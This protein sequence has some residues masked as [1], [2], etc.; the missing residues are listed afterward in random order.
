MTRPVLALALIVTGLAGCASDPKNEPDRIRS[1]DT[2]NTRVQTSRAEPIDESEAL[3]NYRRYLELAEDT[4]ERQEALRRVADLQV[5]V[6]ESG[7]ATGVQVDSIAYYEELLQRYPDAAANDRVLYQLARAHELEGNDAAA[8]ATFERLLTHYP[9][10]S[11]AE[12]VRFRRAELLFRERRYRDAEQAYSQLVA[13]GPGRFYEKALYKQGWARYKQSRYVAALGPFDSLLREHAAAYDDTGVRE[14]AG[15]RATTI[16]LDDSLRTMALSLSLMG[17]AG[18]ALAQLD[19]LGGPPYDRALRHRLASIYEQKQRYTDAA[20]VFANQAERAGSQQDALR[21][22]AALESGGFADR[23]MAAKAGYLRS[24]D[25]AEP[26][27]SANW[28]RELAKHHHALAQKRKDARHY[29]EAEHWY[30][31]YLDKH[32]GFP[33]V[34]EQRFLLA[35]L[36]FEQ[37]RYEQAA[38]EYAAA[39]AA[40]G[41]RAGDAAYAAVLARRGALERLSDNERS[42]RRAQ[43]VEQDLA[44]ATE[45]PGHPQAAAVRLRA[46]EDL[47]ELGRQD[48]AAAAAQPLANAADSGIRLGAL[49]IIAAQAAT[50]GE[51]AAAATAYA[52]AIPLMEIGPRRNE[53]EQAW[54]TALYR[55]GEQA[56]EAG[57]SAT[58][59][60]R[61]REVGRRTPQAAIR[62][63]ADYDAASLL[64]AEQRWDE[65]SGLLE[66]LLARE[67]GHELAP[68]AR[69]KLALAY[70]N[71]G[72]KLDAARTLRSVAQSSGAGEIASAADWQAAELLREACATAEAATAYEQY[73]Q[74]YPD[75]FARGMEARRHLADF[76]ARSG[77]G[78]NYREHLQEIIRADARGGGQRS[79]RSRTLAAEASMELALHA[80]EVFKAARL[81][82]P[83]DRSLKDKTARMDA[84]LT[85]LKQTVDYDVAGVTT[86]ATYRIAELYRQL[87]LDLMDSPRPGG[88]DAE[89]QEQYAV[90]LEEQAFPFEEQAIEVHERNVAR[91]RQGVYDPW[92]GRSYE[93]LAR[94]VPA[95]YGKTEQHSEVIEKW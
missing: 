67:P 68:E 44:F 2:G 46:A 76:E 91:A 93:A 50:A 40:G 38:A 95:Q 56:R 3:E 17:D 35:E 26:E 18:R 19:A 65:A 94:L 83:L 43:V 58:A 69:R 36:L 10:S 9:N 82:L 89:A 86:A 81:K 34:G 57:D 25:I 53:M 85:R 39:A 70:Q 30:R 8:L 78:P 54:A 61:F 4:E 60:N 47:Y 15:S 5:D 49:Q 80:I 71:S 88:L 33:D 20:Q 55:L 31:Y 42:A 72:R 79:D 92:I 62:T 74:R 22:I 23:A 90:L 1:L 27:R 7:A 28:S 6:Q 32:A 48:E 51:Y 45:N 63:T 21:A 41:G 11:A 14:D 52:A 73:L 29:A 77:K 59:I 64:I 87:S 37:Q 66:G 75:D 16:L 24:F 13:A 84:A 12:E